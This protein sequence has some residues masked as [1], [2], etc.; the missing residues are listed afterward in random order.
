[1]DGGV[2]PLAERELA[3]TLVTLAGRSGGVLVECLST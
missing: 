1:V 3:C 2:A